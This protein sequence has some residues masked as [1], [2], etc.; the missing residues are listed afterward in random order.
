MNQTISYY[1]AHAEEFC[2]KTRNADMSF[3]QNKFLKYLKPGAHILDAGCGSGR[4]S[5]RFLQEGFQVT[6]MDASKQICLEAEKLL[7]QEVLCLTFEELD[8]QNEF[9]GIWACASLLHVTGSGMAD[10]L[11]RLKRALKENGIL[12]ASFKY[13][14]GERIA[15]ARFFHD[16]NEKSLQEILEKNGFQIRE[17]FVTEDVRGDRPGEKWINV[18]AE[19]F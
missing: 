14:D 19:N 9:D 7:H 6:A 1:E 12:Y 17:M 10:V 11:F 16:Y 2:E 15:G 3:C 13:G 5:L 4:D 8:F 18:I